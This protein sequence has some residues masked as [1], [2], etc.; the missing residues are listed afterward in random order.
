M[1]A[2]A[3]SLAQ[4]SSTWAGRGTLQ[5]LLGLPIVR[6]HHQRTLELVPGAEGFRLVRAAT[7]PESAADRVVS[8]WRR[9]FGGR[10]AA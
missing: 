6:R 9:L 2:G 5:E 3:G 8:L 4:C 7:P 10:R 1:E